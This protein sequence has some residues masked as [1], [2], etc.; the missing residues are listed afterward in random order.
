MS[1]YEAHTGKIR[2]LEPLEGETYEQQ[3]KRLYFEKGGKGEYY[4]GALFDEFYDDFIRVNKNVLY[5]VFD[6]EEK[7]Y[8]DMFCDLTD[9]GDGTYSFTTRFYNGGTCMSEMVEHELKKI[10]SDEKTV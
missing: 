4:E 3:C 2:K 1:D 7:D 6:H 5:E 10:K 9:N 8:D